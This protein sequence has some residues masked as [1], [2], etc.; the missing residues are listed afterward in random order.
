M[1]ELS[2]YDNVR[3]HPESR[4]IVENPFYLL[5]RNERAYTFALGYTFRKCPELLNRIIKIMDENL[6][7]IDVQIVKTSVSLE[8]IL[9]LSPRKSQVGRTDILVEI[10]PKVSLIIEAKI[11]EKLPDKSQI[12]NYLQILRNKSGKRKRL[13]IISDMD[14]EDGSKEIERLY[15]NRENLKYLRFLSWNEIEEMCNDLN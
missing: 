13:L 6:A 5:G 8:S 14:D 3:R 15:R 1:I 11:G 4:R 10:P 7:D 9:R 2:L 12:S